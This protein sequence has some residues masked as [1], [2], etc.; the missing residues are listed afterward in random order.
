MSTQRT[1]S[2]AETRRETVI[3]SAIT[4]FA[5]TGSLG[6]PVADVA[7]EAGISSAY[8][9]KLFPEKVSLFVAALDRCYDLILDALAAGAA[10]ASS[11]APEVI[12]HAMG[13][14]YANL[15]AQR[16]L[17][18]LQVHAQAATDHPA[19]AD[20]VRNGLARVTTFA[21]D[22]SGAPDDAV[23]EFIARGQLCHLIVAL[24]LDAID[25]PWSRIVSHGFRHPPA[26][27][28]S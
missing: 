5:R 10:S 19:I 13:G 11:D 1:L 4:V 3:R 6:T 16:D 2:T 21:S 26:D 12:L 14:A 22:R 8:V 25:A 24:D 17:L 23:Q 9:F 28:A 15:I 27:T 7:A 20:A 18:L